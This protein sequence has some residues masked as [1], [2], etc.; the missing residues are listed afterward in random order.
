MSLF[1]F[2]KK[3]W[4]VL[5]VSLFLFIIPFFWL[6]P[7][8]MDLGGDSSRLYFYDP[9]SFIKATALYDISI[10]GKGLVQPNYSQL[11]YVSFLALLKLIF[12]SPT[13]LIGIING[14][15][16]AGGFIA[17]Y[18]IVYQLLRE[19]QGKTNKVIY[20]SAILSG[21]FYVV[22]L[23]SIHMAPFWNRALTAH[24]EVFLNPLIFY[25]VLKFFISHKYKYLWIALLATFIFSPNFG[26]N[27]SPS[28]FAFYPLAMIFLFLY[29]KTFVK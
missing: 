22:S 3:Y 16:L 24:N 9:I 17:I 14:L 13:I 4:F 5:F 10:Q 29:V 26:F 25:L 20:F 11:P 1:T 19:V 21:I 28:F 2:I 8:E 23:D 15:K 7:G 27:A 6:K 12:D 18:L